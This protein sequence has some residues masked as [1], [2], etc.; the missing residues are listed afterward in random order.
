M[1][2]TWPRLISIREGPHG[3]GSH[4]P[5]PAGTR[6]THASLAAP[7]FPLDEHDT[8]F[9]TRGGYIAD[10]D[11]ARLKPITTFGDALLHD[12]VAESVE[13]AWYK[14]GKGPL[15]PYRVMPEPRMIAVSARRGI[16]EWLTWREAR[17]PRAAAGAPHAHAHGS[18]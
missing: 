2:P 8:S 5:H 13:H 10:G 15:H 4:D 17:R 14:G 1:M 7:D 18:P 16:A 6:R 12:S 9:V 11:L 3:P